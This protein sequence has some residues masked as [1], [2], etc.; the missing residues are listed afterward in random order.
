MTPAGRRRGDRRRRHPGG[1]ARRDRDHQPAR[2]GRRLGPG[3]R[4]AGPPG[5]GLAGPPHRRALRASCARPATRQ[6]VRERTGLVL[7]PYFSGDQD[8]VAAA[9][10][11]GGRAGGLRHD[12]L[13]AALQADRPPRDRP[14]QRLADDA[15]RHPPAAPGTR[16]SARCSASTR[17][18]LPEPLP[19][20]HVY[21]TTSRVRRRGAGGGDRRRPAG[22]ALRPGLPPGRHREEHLR[23][24]QLRPAQHRARGAG[25]GRGAAGDG[26][27][28]HRRG[29]RPT[30]S[31]PRSSS[32]APPCSGCATASA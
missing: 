30:R 3:E 4:R 27:L 20:A 31:R 6:L 28:R 32:P 1:R 26:R 11:R 21:G 22:G 8:R 13:L 5:A 18:R 7:D 15:L 29:S 23:D 12:R 25:A 24:R 19:S 10:R 16:S 17:P 9:Q 14:H 2:D